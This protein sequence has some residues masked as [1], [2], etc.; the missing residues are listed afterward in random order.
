MTRRY[1]ESGLPDA[2]DASIRYL[3]SAAALRSIEAD[4]YWP[5]WNSPW[6]HMTLLWELDL[7]ERIPERAAHRM[8]ISLATQYTK[9]F[10]GFDD[11]IS[12]TGY[13]YQKV[14]WCHCSLGTILQV[15]SACGQDIDRILPWTRSWLLQHQLPDGGLNCEEAAYLKPSAKSSIV[16]TLPPLEAILALSKGKPT[17][18]EA[19]FLDKGAHYLLAHRMFRAAGAEGRIINPDWTRPSFPRFY[20]YDILRGLVILVR[21][22]HINNRTLPLDAIKESLNILE[23]S[24]ADGNIRV[25]RLA[26]HGVDTLMPEPGGDLRR[27]GQASTFDLL[28]H[29]GRVG[30]ISRELTRSWKF[31]K[32][33]LDAIAH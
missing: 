2:I 29:A 19:A 16:S 6:W 3:N 7:A 12:T 18:A 23:T 17:A 20:D 10:P 30:E 5:K 31:V 13:R 9:R 32:R 21:W 25:L 24:F 33:A 1:P 22:A 8:A 28:L 26:W 27:G 14:P 11:T 4:P 15:L